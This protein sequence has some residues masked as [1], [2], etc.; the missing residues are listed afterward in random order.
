MMISQPYR[1]IPTCYCLQLKKSF[2]SFYSLSFRY[3]SNAY[4]LKLYTFHTEG[5]WSAQIIFCL[6][7]VSSA[8]KRSLTDSKLLWCESELWPFFAFSYF[9]KKK[10]RD[11]VNNLDIETHL[12]VKLC[13]VNP[14]KTIE[15]TQ[16]SNQFS[17]L[18]TLLLLELKVNRQH[19]CRTSDVSEMLNHIE[20]ADYRC[21]VFSPLSV[22]EPYLMKLKGYSSGA[23]I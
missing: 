11:F 12:A 22:S 20:P 14:R 21:V 1:C 23:G 2:R 19:H 9:S 13:S 10:K 7:R 5:Q 8:G 17:F 18:F 6:Y 4:Q 3:N 15:Q 16:W